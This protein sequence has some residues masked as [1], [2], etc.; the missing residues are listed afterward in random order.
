MLG[1]TLLN[2]CPQVAQAVARLIL[3]KPDA[4][5]EMEMYPDGSGGF[6]RSYYC[7]AQ[8][9]SV[10]VSSLEQWLKDEMD[11]NHT[12]EFERFQFPEEVKLAA[13]LVLDGKDIRSVDSFKKCDCVRFVWGKHLPLA[14]QTQFVE[15]GV[16][17][18]KHCAVA[19]RLE[20]Q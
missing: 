16:K 18:A 15:R 5:P 4:E 3:G 11:V 10:T 7:A 2:G 12:G 17:D 1:A 8:Q 14:S 19:G 20:E 13:K 9:K 6:E